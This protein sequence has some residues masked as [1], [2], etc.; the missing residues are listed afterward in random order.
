MRRS[1]FSG[2]SETPATESQSRQRPCEGPSGILQ[3]VKKGKL[4]GQ[5]FSRSSIRASIFGCV[6]PEHE[7]AASTV[8]PLGFYIEWFF[9][10]SD[11]F[12][13]FCS[14]DALP[15]WALPGWALPGWFSCA[16]AKQFD[17]L[18]KWLKKLFQ[19]VVSDTIDRQKLILGCRHFIRHLR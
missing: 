13:D 3:T 11:G 12:G 16:I 15:G 5:Q 6:L 1:D 10:L 7:T 17:H 8:S 2:K 19:L 18:G 9:L 14:L 4:D